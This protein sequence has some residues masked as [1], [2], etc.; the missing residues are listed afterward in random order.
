MW[1][2]CSQEIDNWIEDSGY[3]SVCHVEGGDEL[4]GE[5]LV[6][7]FVYVPPFVCES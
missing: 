7:R 3:V 2:S 6:F 1:E 4:K 5:A